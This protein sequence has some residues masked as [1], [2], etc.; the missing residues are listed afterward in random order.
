MTNYKVESNYFYEK[1]IVAFFAGRMT[2]AERKDAAIDTRGVKNCYL[3]LVQSLN[4]KKYV[5]N[6]L[7]IETRVPISVSD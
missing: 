4:L 3:N 7:N 2:R 1:R 6:V 5:E